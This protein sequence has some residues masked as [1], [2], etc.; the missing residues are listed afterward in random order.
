MKTKILVIIS[1]LVLSFSFLS[2]EFTTAQSSSPV[3]KIGIVNVKRVLVECEA[4]T[5]FME[6]ARAEIEKIRTEQEEIQASIKIL[7]S[8]LNSKKYKIGTDEFFKKN[9]E[10][11]EKEN[12]LNLLTEFKNQELTLKNQLWQMD[13]YQKIMTIAQEIGK[14]KDLYLVLSVEDVE[15]APQL[16]PEDFALILKTH[17]VLYSAEGMDLTELVISRMNQLK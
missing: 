16:R 14:E 1:L 10:L 15:L 2:H 6:K 7:E 17:Q 11:A 9:Q 4:T 5:K 12:Q 8:E 13:V 3:S